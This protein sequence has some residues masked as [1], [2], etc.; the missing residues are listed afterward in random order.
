V[1]PDL[2]RRGCV[3]T[4][5]A[6]ACRLREFGDAE[7]ADIVASGDGVVAAASTDGTVAVWDAETGAE[8][9]VVDGARAVS[10]MAVSADGQVVAATDAGGPVR[11]FDQAGARQAVVEVPQG[12]LVGWIALSPDGTFVAMALEPDSFD[13]IGSVQVVDIERSVVTTTVDA[14]GTDIAFSP[15]GARLAATDGNDVT[16]VSLADDGAPAVTLSGHLGLVWSIAFAADGA[17]MATTSSDGTVRVWDT[18]TGA[19]RLVLPGHERVSRAAAF[20]D[21]A[22]LASGGVGGVA[23]VWALDIDDLIAIA[24]D[25]LTRRL[26]DAECREYLH[27]DACP[28]GR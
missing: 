26:T 27:V 19:P 4:L 25:K 2:V 20:I 6:A 17:T 18:R 10:D 14:W 22:M 1:E 9:F 5:P 21:D 23:R 16:V 28:A 13:G 11:V 12:H 3:G 15:D 24:D 8:R 7:P